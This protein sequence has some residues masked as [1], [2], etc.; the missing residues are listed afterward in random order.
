MKTP[1]LFFISLILVTKLA[2]QETKN[3]RYYLDSVEFTYV[4]NF[5]INPKNLDS[6]RVTHE[7][8]NGEVYFF[9]KT[10]NALFLSPLDIIDQYTKIDPIKTTIF[11][12]INGADIFDLAEVKIDPS[13][14][15]YVNITNPS[16]A[17]YINSSSLDNFRIVD[18][19]LEQKGRKPVIRIRGSSDLLSSY[20]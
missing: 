10:K 13:F 20:K 18:I 8:E 14:F 17:N 19:I 12:K 11:F 5:H 4:S 9:S 3:P 15:I 7:S 16:D 2:A 6:I 1:L